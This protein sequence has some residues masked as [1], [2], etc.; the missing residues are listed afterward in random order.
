MTQWEAIILDSQSQPIKKI[1]SRK[2]VQTV[3]CL[4][5]KHE[6]EA[7]EFGSQAPW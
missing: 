5:C 1:Q 2:R 3:K 7:T 4:L 6:E